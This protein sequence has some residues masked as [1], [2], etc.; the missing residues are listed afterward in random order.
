MATPTQA[1]SLVGARGQPRPRLSLGD[2]TVSRVVL[3]SCK[4]VVESSQHTAGS[5]GNYDDHTLR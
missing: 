3:T 1:Y 5:D 2:P 4:I